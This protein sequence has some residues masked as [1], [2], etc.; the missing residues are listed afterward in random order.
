VGDEIKKR[1][2]SLERMSFVVKVNVIVLLYE[3]FNAS[4]NYEEWN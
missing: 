2:P 3:F 1:N 4:A